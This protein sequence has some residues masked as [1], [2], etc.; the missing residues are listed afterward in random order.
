MTATPPITPGMPA[1]FPFWD[2]SLVAYGRDEV[3][4]ACLGLQDRLGLDVNLVLFAVWL[5]VEG[6]SLGAPSDGEK[7]TPGS[8]GLAEAR[9]AVLSE[10]ARRWQA[11][12]VIPLRNS[13]RQL[14]APRSAVPTAVPTV[15][16]EALRKQIKAAELEA[17]R[18]E[19]W[20]LQQAAA[21][22][23]RVSRE[24]GNARSI[25]DQAHLHLQALLRMVGAASAAEDRQ[26][27]ALIV[28]RTLAADGKR[29]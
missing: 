27:L 24:A 16:R 12:V 5:A 13:R 9:L 17:E 26:A 19:Q 3:A 10:D 21:A 14:R 25:A 22:V 6:R 2:W 23:P 29:S 8:V 15:D 11:E 20:L 1:R 4:A 7:A 28:D 18:L